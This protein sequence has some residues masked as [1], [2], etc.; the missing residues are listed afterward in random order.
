LEGELKTS[1]AESEAMESRIEARLTGM[2]VDL[3]KRE[4]RMLLAVECRAD[5]PEKRPFS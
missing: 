5:A 2:Q 4:T 1:R 3:A